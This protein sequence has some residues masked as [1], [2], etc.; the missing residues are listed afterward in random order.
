LGAETES[1][2]GKGTKKEVG[3]IERKELYEVRISERK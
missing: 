1:E 2:G 3:M